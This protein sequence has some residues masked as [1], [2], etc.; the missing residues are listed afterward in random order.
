MNLRFVAPDVGL[1]RLAQATIQ[2]DLHFIRPEMISKAI[3]MECR[4]ECHIN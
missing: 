4:G 3:E 2:L 1:N